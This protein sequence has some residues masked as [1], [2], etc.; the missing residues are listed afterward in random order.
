MQN[1]WQNLIKGARERSR[2]ITAD[3]LAAEKPEPKPLP[4]LPDVVEQA[5]Q[6]WLSAQNYYNNVSD[7]DLVDHAVYLMQAAEKKYMYLLK[8]ARKEGIT[9]SPYS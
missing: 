8:L 3:L 9:H 1:L 5:R 7:S 6:E 2:A 4:P